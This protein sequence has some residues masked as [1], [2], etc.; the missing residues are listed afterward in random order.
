[1]INNELVWQ[2]YIEKLI[3]DAYANWNNLEEID[4]QV[5]DT[6]L[7]A[8]GMTTQFFKVF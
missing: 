3:K 6:A 2:A 5:N 1:M 7:L 8:M 4:A